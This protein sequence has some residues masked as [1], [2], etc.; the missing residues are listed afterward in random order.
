MTL[1]YFFSYFQ[2]LTCFPPQITGVY[3]PS[4]PA[5][6]DVGHVTD[7]GAGCGG[8]VCAARR[9]ASM[10]TT[11][12]CGPDAPRA[13]VKSQRSESFSEA[14]VSKSRSPGRARHKLSNHCAGKAGVFPL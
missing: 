9:A 7:V 6:G 10:R 12:P 3:R 2:N 4:C 11:K 8:R 14:M 1:R 13:G 5:R